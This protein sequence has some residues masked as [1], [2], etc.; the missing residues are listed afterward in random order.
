[1]SCIFCRIANKELPAEILYETDKVMSILDINPIHYGH[2]LVIPKQ[3]CVDF[4]TV[5]REDLHQ[6]LE[7]AQIVAKAI[8]KSLGLNGFNVFSNNGSIAGQSVFHFH[9]HVTPRYENDNIR[10]VLDLKSY[11][12]GD[13]A[14]YG[15]KIRKHIP[16]N[17]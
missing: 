12:Q 17:V 9:I 2:A 4:L 5:P 8:V 11:A 16:L 10:F 1:V 14:A 3:H 15:A 6:V 13:M 7:A